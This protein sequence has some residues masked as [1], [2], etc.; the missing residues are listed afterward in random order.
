LKDLLKQ[1]ALGGDVSKVAL[2]EFAEDMEH[3]EQQMADIQ[4]FDARL[5]ETKED[6]KRKD[7]EAEEK[8]RRENRKA[9][10]LVNLNEDPQLS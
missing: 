7:L 4:D 6:D 1:M 9:P 2:Q 3:A 10:H 8:R 5:A